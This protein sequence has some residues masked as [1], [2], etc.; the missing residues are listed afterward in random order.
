MKRIAIIL[1]ISLHMCGA[2]LGRVSCRHT[3]HITAL[4]ICSSWA[5]ALSGGAR[6]LFATE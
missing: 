2:G 5:A 1:C 3:V 4:E 6:F